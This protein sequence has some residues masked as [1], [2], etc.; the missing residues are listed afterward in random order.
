MCAYFKW[1]IEG[2]DKC[3][4]AQ[5]DIKVGVALISTQSLIRHEE[6]GGFFWWDEF[7]SEMQWTN[8]IYSN[9]IA[10]SRVKSIS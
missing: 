4:N 8:K 2:S 3:V 6:E 1:D 9:S 7:I 5:I 10:K